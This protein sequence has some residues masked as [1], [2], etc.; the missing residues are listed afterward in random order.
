MVQA[1][2]ARKS[3]GKPPIPWAPLDPCQN[4]SGLRPLG[5]WI[6]GVRGQR[7]AQDHEL[8]TSQ[9]SKWG[10]H[11]QGGPFTRASDV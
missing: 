11:K 10:V 8:A 9:G 5:V 7:Y 2:K 1:S 4:P 6:V 3:C